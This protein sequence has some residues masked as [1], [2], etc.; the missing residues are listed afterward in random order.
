M[1]TVSEVLSWNLKNLNL[2]CDGDT[3][4]EYVVSTVMKKSISSWR[5]MLTDTLVGEDVDTATI[6]DC[7][8]S[9]GAMSKSDQNYK[10]AF[11]F[12]EKFT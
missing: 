10:L 4:D 7:D 2:D 8:T 3:M 12:F 9:R 6:K 11:S 5:M 1:I